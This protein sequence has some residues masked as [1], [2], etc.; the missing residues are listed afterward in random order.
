MGAMDRFAHSAMGAANKAM[1]D[2]QFTNAREQHARARLR[3]SWSN[4]LSAG[5]S[6]AAAVLGVSDDA[7]DDE[8]RQAFRTKARTMHTDT[9]GAGGDLDALKEARDVMLR[10]GVNQNEE[11]QVKGG[12]VYCRGRGRVPS[13]TS[14]GSDLCIACNGTG[15]A[16]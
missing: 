15:N 7:T 3:E 13:T 9:G 11:M 10:R 14:W 5:V 12:C 4:R 1:R 8:V 2:E 6:N 16:P